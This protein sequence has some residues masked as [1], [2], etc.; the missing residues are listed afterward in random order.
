MNI[1]F[2]LEPNAYFF[3]ISFYALYEKALPQVTMY[4]FVVYPLE[5]KEKESKSTDQRLILMN[6]ESKYFF[7]QEA[8][9]HFH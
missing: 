3:Y 6:M 5:N 1:S 9:T 8:A 4:C 2:H 7:S